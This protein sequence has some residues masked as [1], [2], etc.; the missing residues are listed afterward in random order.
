MKKDKAISYGY[1]I[2]GLEIGYGMSNILMGDIS[3]INAAWVISGGLWLLTTALK[4]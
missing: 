1:V 2:G 3:P 4:V